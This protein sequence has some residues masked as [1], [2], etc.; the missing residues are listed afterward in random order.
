MDITGNEKK[1]IIITVHEI[2]KNIKN[3]NNTHEKQ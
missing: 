1:I 3:K 2:K